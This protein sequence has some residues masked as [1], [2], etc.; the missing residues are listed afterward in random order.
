MLSLFLD[1]EMLSDSFDVDD[2]KTMLSDLGVQD[3]ECYGQTGCIPLRDMRKLADAVTTDLTSNG[4][5]HNL[6]HEVRCC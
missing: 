2:L 5:T 4:R 6:A 1:E 3:D